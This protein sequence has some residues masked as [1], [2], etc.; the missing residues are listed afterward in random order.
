LNVF[1]SA[2]NYDPV[3]SGV[4]PD[5][6][7]RLGPIEPVLERIDPLLAEPIELTPAE[8]QNLVAFVR[9]GLLDE[10][11]KRQSLCR[12]APESVPSGFT[13]M[14]FEECPQRR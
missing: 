14:T 6:T 5:L 3:S 4:A 12:L 8:F 10:R 11:A 2:R 13:T 1:A 9:D 7:H